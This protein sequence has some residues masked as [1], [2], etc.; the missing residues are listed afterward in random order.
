MINSIQVLRGIAALLVVVHHSFLYGHET[1]PGV[2]FKSGA[3]GVDIFFA[4]SG[5]VMFLTARGQTPGQFF[6]RRLVR[7]VPLFWFFMVVKIAFISLATF[8]SRGDGLD[9]TYIIQS[10][11]F[12]PARGA[13]GHVFPLIGVSWTLQFEMYFYLVCAF[14]LAFSPRRFVPVVCATIIAGVG[15]GLPWMLTQDTSPAPLFILSPIALEFLGGV[16]AALIWSKD[17]RLPIWVNI[18]ILLAGAAAL[19]V[20]P[21]QEIF[22]LT[23]FIWWGVPAAVIT[24]AFLAL[25]EQ[26]PFARMKFPLLLGDASYAIYLAHTAVIPLLGSALNKLGFGLAA[27]PAL[28]VGSVVTGIAVHFVVEKPLLRGARAILWPAPRK[29]KEIRW[30]AE[31]P[32]SR[33]KAVRWPEDRGTS[34]IGSDVLL[35][36]VVLISAS[37][38]ALMVLS[39][40]GSGLISTSGISHP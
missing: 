5:V 21:S 22:D 36:T 25:E 37:S 19:F 9:L 12:I 24:W 6:L 17:F 32:V 1:K 30:P 33:P 28:V 7:I 3:V 23:R 27:V 11:L 29:P 38:V 16:L 14:A 10:F 18:P 13:D 39:T 35:A 34:R 40:W 15:A 31:V 8:K 20:A 26:L 2:F 4:I